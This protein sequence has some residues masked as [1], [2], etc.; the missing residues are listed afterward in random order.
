MERCNI[1]NIFQPRDSLRL[2]RQSPLQM[3]ILLPSNS[4]LTAFKF[5][6]ISSGSGLGVQELRRLPFD[7]YGT[8]G[9]SGENMH[10]DD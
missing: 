7:E 6:S 9:I 8:S 3:L 10:N 2:I 1:I 4:P 5:L